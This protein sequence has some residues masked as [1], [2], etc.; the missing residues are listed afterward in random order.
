VDW[1]SEYERL[2]KSVEEK[3]SEP[4]ENI[5][6]LEP[7][8]KWMEIKAKDRD[9]VKA[10]LEEVN[11]LSVLSPE[12]EG[13]KEW[14]Q[15][16]YR[17]FEYAQSSGENTARGACM[18][19][20]YVTDSSFPGF[21]SWER[22]I[23]R[24][25]L[26]GR[27]IYL[28][29][30]ETGFDIP[31]I[32]RR[33]QCMINFSI[34]DVESN[35]RGFGVYENREVVF[36]YLDEDGNI[37]LPDHDFEM[38][39][40]RRS[41]F[42]RM[43]EGTPSKPTDLGL[44]MIDTVR[45]EAKWWEF[46][47]EYNDAT[48]LMDEFYED[49]ICKTPPNAPH[50][51]HE[52]FYYWLAEQYGLEKSMAY[53]KGFYATI[54]GKVE[55][56]KGKERVPAGGAVVTV[57]DPHDGKTWETTADEAGNYEINDAI[58]HE[59]CGPFPITARHDL[60]QIVDEYRGPLKSPD[61][62]CRFRKDLLI[63]QSDV[64][65]SLRIRKTSVK[66]IASHDNSEMYEGPCLTYTVD[67]HTLRE[68]AEA[69]VMV[70]ME[71]VERQDMPIYNQTWE[72]YQPLNLELVSFDFSSR[73][74]K[75]NSGEFSGPGC[76][77]GGYKTT[78]ET[79]GSGENQRIENRMFMTQAPWIVV[80]DNE[81]GKAVK[82]V[83]FGYTV[84]FDINQKEKFHTTRYGDAG[85]EEKSDFN[86]TTA[87]ETFEIGPVG[88]LIQDPTVKSSDTWLQDYLKRQGLS[89]P[90]GINPPTPSNEETIQEIP[91]DV[92]VKTGDGIH[93]FGGDGRNTV[94]KKLAHGKQ[95]ETLHYHWQMTR[96]K[97]SE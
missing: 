30:L 34:G 13:L 48:S 14:T 18:Q 94:V 58:L 28:K 50:Q 79:Y 49:S 80:F 83:P 60:D 45:R 56:E 21:E 37:N 1:A 81:T 77:A 35:S 33:A 97:K 87:P 67:E 7:Y 88:D 73:E 46:E 75:L 71:L 85:T 72:Y 86:V 61:S 64:D 52:S 78:T 44:E 31:D 11:R 55:K 39:C 5:K 89:L 70:S 59:D 16:F 36:G 74:F 65:A 82:I 54:Y 96:R 51:G 95:E 47:W 17:L 76:A 93:H 22:V 68:A 92:L 12:D 32:K 69:T 19:F 84:A 53:N 10:L 24:L 3:E 25:N 90:A 4:V 42:T 23:T 8:L 9:E 6:F 43:S 63:K 27:K 15:K 41:A 26:D 29:A 66:T 20:M 38:M 40:E 57:T 2:K 91:P 62:S